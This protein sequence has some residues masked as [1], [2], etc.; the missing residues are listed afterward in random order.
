MASSA[1]KNHQ[2]A[3]DRKTSGRLLGEKGDPSRPN[4]KRRRLPDL[5]TVLD[6]FD[7]M[8]EPLE[9]E[10]APGDFWIEPEEWDME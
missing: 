6:A 10:P 8:D 4:P 9:P 5:Q 1:A 3:S 7:P 2:P